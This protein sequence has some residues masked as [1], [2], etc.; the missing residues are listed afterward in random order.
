MFMFPLKNLARKGLSGYNGLPHVHTHKPGFSVTIAFVNC[1]TDI[2][3]D[4][5]TIA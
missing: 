2:D 1:Y 3:C 4:V 5:F